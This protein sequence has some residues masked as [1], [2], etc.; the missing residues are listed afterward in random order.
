MAVSKTASTAVVAINDNPSSSS[1]ELA[2]HLIAEDTL[3]IESRVIVGI[4]DHQ[5][6]LDDSIQADVDEGTSAN[7]V[8]HNPLMRLTLD[9]FKSCRITLDGL[10]SIID[11]IR[12]F[13]ECSPA[14]AKRLWQL[15]YHDT[16]FFSSGIPVEFHQFS[17]RGGPKTPV[18][19]FNV[20]LRILALVPGPQGKALRKAQADV[21]TRALAGDL[22]LVADI[23]ATGDVSNKTKTFATITSTS[24]DSLVTHTE[25]Q[26]AHISC[27]TATA[28]SKR[29]R[30]QTTSCMTS[31]VS[32]YQRTQD[33][34]VYSTWIDGSSLIDQYWDAQNEAQC[35]NGLGDSR[36]VYFIRQIGTTMVKVGFS[37]DPSNR[38]RT[39][40]CGNAFDLRIEHQVA[41]THYQELESCLHAFLTKEGKH[42]RREW[43]DIASDTDFDAI[44]DEAVAIYLTF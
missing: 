25:H 28:G 12:Y 44:V 15:Q 19:A 26:D 14:Y 16:K 8:L 38:L 36:I 39:L 23:I 9:D 31:I 24:H 40:Q 6:A 21:S 18:A 3:R 37:R 17:S 41:T 33:V 5:T 4:D 35:K 42:V 13:R 20:L 22:T 30:E 27:A 11:A 29:S 32:K 43:F 34:N 2:K 10:I 7:P 1:T